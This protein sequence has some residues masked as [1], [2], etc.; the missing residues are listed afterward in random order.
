MRSEQPLTCPR[1]GKADIPPTFWL[2]FSQQQAIHPWCEGLWS[3]L[4]DKSKVKIEKLARLCAEDPKKAQLAALVHG[5]K[6]SR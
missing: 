3:K 5:Q 4:N 6:E 2:W 1:C